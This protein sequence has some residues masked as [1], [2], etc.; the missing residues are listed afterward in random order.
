MV[1]G[2]QYIVALVF[3]TVGGAIT[4]F[5]STYIRKD[6]AI[7]R[8]PRAPGQIVRSEVTSREVRDQDPSSPLRTRIVTY[9]EPSIHFTYTVGER[10]FEGTQ[11]ARNVPSNNLRDPAQACVGRY[12][13]GARVEVLYDPADP[14]TGYLENSTSIG[15]VILVSFGGFFVFLGVLFTVIFVL[16]G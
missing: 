1:F 2:P 11:V 4:L 3:L 6:R 8:W 13:A 12:P 14:A 15:A 7:R 10:T 9:Y 5:G 16:T